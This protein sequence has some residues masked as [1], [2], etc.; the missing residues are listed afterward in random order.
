DEGIYIE[1]GGAVPMGGED[2]Q[3]AVVADVATDP[4]GQVL[5][6]GVGRIFEIYVVAPIE[7]RLVLTKGG[8]FSHYEFVQPLSDRLTDEAWQ[9]MLD[10][11]NTPPLAEWTNSFMVEQN[12][13][14]PLA[15]HIREYTKQLIEARWYSNPELVESYL[16]GAALNDL[17]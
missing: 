12:A 4:N 16:T 15:D 7:G 6:E 1:G 10:E 5:E 2:L 13:A 9:A 8:V 3:A 14:V 11:G 17:R